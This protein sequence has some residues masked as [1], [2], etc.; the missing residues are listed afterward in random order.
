MAS[1]E[2]WRLLPFSR[3]PAGEQM[4]WAEAMLANVRAPALRWRRI[5][6]EALVLG[7]R[8]AETEADL[9]A[10]HAAGLCVYRRSTGGTAVLSGPD[11]LGLDIALPAGHRLALPNVTESYRWLGE[12]L[13]SGLRALGVVAE[14]VSPATARSQDPMIAPNDP[15]RLACFAILSPYEVTV[16]GR[17]LIGLA[18]ARRHAGSLL[19]AGILLRW[20]AERLAELLT[21]PPNRRES[22]AHALR[23]RAIGLDEIG[24][25]LGDDSLMDHLNESIARA[26]GAT[27]TP[28]GWSAAERAGYEQSRPGFAPI[29]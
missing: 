14:P 13:A 11:L 27:L 18:Q 22:I 21:I 2:T 6:P 20:D 29:V 25:N 23:D 1:S 5:E 12:A 8:Q 15:I 24:L 16:S 26:A 10:C 9:A 7:R 17:K 3:L 19:Q 28:D 4:A